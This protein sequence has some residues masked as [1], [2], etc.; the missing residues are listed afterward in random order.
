M[1][2]QRSLFIFRGQQKNESA[3]KTSIGVLRN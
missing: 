1:L 3:D 2:T